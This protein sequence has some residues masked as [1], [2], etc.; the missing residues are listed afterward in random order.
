MQIP[1]KIFIFHI[2]VHILTTR[3]LHGQVQKKSKLKTI[4]TKQKH[5]VRIIF[6]E[7]RLCH[8]RPF[9]KTFTSIKCISA[10]YI[11]KSKFHA[12]IKKVILFLGSLQN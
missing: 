3:T 9:L 2:F 8:S 7:D 4:N 12:Q 6:N 10:E 11:S 1:L 5:A